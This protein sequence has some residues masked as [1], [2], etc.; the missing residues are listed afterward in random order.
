MDL[1]RRESEELISG[2]G[3]AQDNGV[4]MMTRILSYI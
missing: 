1:F 3:V 4:A 2:G